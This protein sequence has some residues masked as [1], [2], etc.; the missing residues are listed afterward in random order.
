MKKRDIIEVTIEGLEFGGMGYAKI[1]NNIIYCKGTIPGQKVRL[2]VK[3]MRKGKVDTK[4]LNVI[5]KSDLETVTPCDHVDVCG[6]C[7]MLTL[8]YN[9]QLEYKKNQ[10]L[11]IFKAA[12]HSEI[13]DIE[14]IGSPKSLRY[15]NKM[16]YSFGDETKGGPLNIGMHMMGRA[17]SVVNTDT[18]KIVTKDYLQIL[19][20]TRNYFTQR[21]ITYYRVM[22]R[23]GYLRNLIIRQGENT[24]ELFVNLVT[25]SQLTLDLSTY[26]EE[27]LQL[28]LDSKIVGIIHTINDNFSDAV[29][30]DQVISLYGRDYFYEQL[31]NKTFIIS[32]FSFFQTNT[33]GAEVLY[34]T[35]LS[36]IKDQKDI[37]FDLYSGTGT[38]G[39][40]A[41]AK[42]KKVIGIEIIEEAVKMA[43]KNA[44][45]NNIKN[46]EFIAGD[47]KEEVV[48]LTDSPELII[49]DP[50]RSG[51]HPKAIGDIISFNAKE[52][53]YISCNPKALA[54]DLKHLKSAG[55]KIQEIKAVDMFPNTGH[56]ETVCL[57]SKLRTDQQI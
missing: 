54:I 44:E 57:L 24:K 20:T 8:E 28:K 9:K 34:N 40:M 13:T 33:L 14:I 48:K 42:A 23:E 55:Y 6:G 15:K 47:V 5:E 18:C 43:K 19:N 22:Q 7:T 45:L 2:L 31:N 56:C 38:I 41:S 39:I 25:T 50:P 4:L 51:I 11:D 30:P 3:S 26:V 32:P 49:L 37:I 1:E 12:D 17:N 53:L 36:M 27:L 52:I 46:A 21:N 16:E 10:L 35:A 29:I